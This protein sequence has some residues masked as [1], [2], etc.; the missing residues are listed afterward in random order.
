MIEFNK[1]PES[2]KIDKVKT[3]VIEHIKAKS[4]SIHFDNMDSDSKFHLSLSKSIY[5]KHYQI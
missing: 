1:G 4:V 5:L 2:A 3:K